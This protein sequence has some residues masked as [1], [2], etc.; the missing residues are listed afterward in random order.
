MA[1][2]TFSQQANPTATAG[3]WG[4]MLRNLGESWGNPGIADSPLKGEV[5]IKDSPR[6][7]H[8]FI[9]LEIEQH[10]NAGG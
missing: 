6:T 4:K 10:P 2:L 9:M 7:T 3:M 1:S 8:A 5:K